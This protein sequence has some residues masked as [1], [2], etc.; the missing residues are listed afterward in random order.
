MTVKT[1]N[2]ILVLPSLRTLRDYKNYINPIRGFNPALI[3]DLRKK[4]VDFSG[5]ER[6]VT[7]LFDEMKIQED[8]VWHKHSGELIGF[9]DLGDINTNYTE[10]C[11]RTCNTYW[12][13]L[14]EVLSILS[15]LAL[16]H[17][18]Q[19]VSQLIK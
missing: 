7:I 6:F 10:R 15:R 3:N 11:R 9:V 17:L 12:C 18:Q 13:F 5:P 19:L 2:G 1:G 4:T 8:L 14:Q 16:H